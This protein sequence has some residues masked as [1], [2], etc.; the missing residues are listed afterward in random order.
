M[1]AGSRKQVF[2][3]QVLAEE[4][5]LGWACHRGAGNANN[6]KTVKTCRTR[7]PKIDGRANFLLKHGHS[8]LKQDR[9]HGSSASFQGNGHLLHG[10]CPVCEPNI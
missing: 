10:S 4:G 9:V 6:A 5:W 2:V 8:T 7:N 3:S 1:N